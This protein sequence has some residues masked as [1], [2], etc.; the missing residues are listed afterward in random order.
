MADEKKQELNLEELES[1]DGGFAVTCDHLKKGV[2]VEGDDETLKR[3]ATIV[4]D[5]RR[6]L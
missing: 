2:E 5:G 6:V 3:N 1:V 4:V